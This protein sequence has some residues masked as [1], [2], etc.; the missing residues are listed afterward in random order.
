MPLCS[1]CGIM[2]KLIVVVAIL[3]CQPVTHAM[4]PLHK[5]VKEGNLEEVAALIKAGAD[6]NEYDGIQTPLEV[7]MWTYAW[8][9][10]RQIKY[11]EIVELLLKKG[12]NPNRSFFGICTPLMDAIATC[13]TS[14][15]NLMLE[16]SRYPI[17][18]KEQ[19]LHIAA[20]RGYVGI[21]DKLLNLGVNVND[22]DSL[23]RGWT[24]LHCAVECGWSS[25]V[26]FLL[27]HHANRDQQDDYGCTPANLAASRGNEPIAA[28]LTAWPKIQ[29]ANVR[30]TLLMGLHPRAGA[31]SSL[32][33]LSHD[34]L[35]II[36][37]EYVHPEY[38]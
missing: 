25:V 11:L 28:L 6:V 37:E 19:L 13:M 8:T 31:A 32:N 20:S 30:L 12:A 17:E 10:H 18:K 14:I 3:L 36:A 24:P 2:N 29:C 1:V 4:H 35:R 34:V 33:V 7:A 38:Y 15:V 26:R 27:E 9:C 16:H 21:V 5:A 22:Q 23:Y